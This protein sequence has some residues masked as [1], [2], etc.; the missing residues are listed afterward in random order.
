MPV[1]VCPERIKWQEKLTVNVGDTIP[2]TGA[3]DGIKRKGKCQLSAS[4]LRLST[5]C[6]LP[7]KCSAVPLLPWWT[8]F[9]LRHSVSAFQNVINVPPPLLLT[10]RFS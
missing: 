7:H 4:F 10:V 3:L 2:Y 9:S 5:F 8:E 1:R 6:L